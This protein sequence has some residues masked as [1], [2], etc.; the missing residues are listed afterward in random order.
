MDGWMD[1]LTDRQID[2]QLDALYNIY[3]EDE[4]DIAD[5]PY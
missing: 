5:G 3:W 4:L 1:D 2:R